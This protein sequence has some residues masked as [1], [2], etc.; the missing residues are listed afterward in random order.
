[1][2]SYQ[3]LV[4]VQGSSEISEQ[5]IDPH[6]VYPEI[7]LSIR[8]LMEVEVQELILVPVCVRVYLQ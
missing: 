2:W 5:S 4:T 8:V 7:I 6:A 1:M 3:F